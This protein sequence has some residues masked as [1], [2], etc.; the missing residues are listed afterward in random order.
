MV[1]GRAVLA[2]ALKAYLKSKAACACWCLKRKAAGD[3]VDD[4][5]GEQQE[6]EEEPQQERRRARDSSIL[7]ALV[8]VG[9]RSCC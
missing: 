7:Q 9:K 8:L 3:A 6:E 5:G 4:G 2:L 1:A